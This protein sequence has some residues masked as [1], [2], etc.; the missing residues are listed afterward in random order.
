[1]KNPLP[2]LTIQPIETRIFKLGENLKDFILQHLPSKPAEKSVLAI[3]SKIMSLSEGRVVRHDSIEKGALVQQEADHYLGEIAYGCHLTIKHGLFIPSAGI[4]ESNSQDGDYILFPVDPFASAK[5]LWAELRQA[6]GL[7]ELG[8]IITDSH[9]TP[10]RKGVT[11]ISLA[12]W[13]FRAVKNLVGTEDLFG[14]QLVMTNIN[15][16]D[17]LASA[18]TYMMGEGKE[19]QPLCLMTGTNVDFSETTNP[20][21]VTIPLKQDLYYPLFSGLMKP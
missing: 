4:D 21:E 12:H 13:G 17:G 10:L 11:G 15:A 19:C 7:N 20:S 14:R 6:W 9:T 2:P 5:K 18:A 16:A 3:T 1:M 8:L